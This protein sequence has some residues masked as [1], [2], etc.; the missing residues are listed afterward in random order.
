MRT[1]RPT[2]RRVYLPGLDIVTMQQLGEAPASDLAALDAKL[3]VVREQYRFVDALLADAVAGLG[4]RDVLVLVGDPGRL[5][6]AGAQPAEG[7]LVLAGARS[8]GRRPG[9]R[10][11]ARRRTDRAAPAGPAQEPRARRA[12]SWRRPSPSPS[13]A[14]TRCAQSTPTAAVRR[15]VPADSAFDQDVLEQLKS[16]GY[17]Q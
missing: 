16:L 6:R 9:Q 5:A 7:L 13:A 8:R 1:P 2:S 12:R 14:S 10:L 17:I 3:G 15:R 11:R 4:P